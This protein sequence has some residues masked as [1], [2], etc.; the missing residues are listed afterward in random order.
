MSFLC[1]K[2]FCSSGSAATDSQTAVPQ[3][4]IYATLGLPLNLTCTYNCS[5]GWVRS[6]WCLWKVGQSDCQPVQSKG[7]LSEHRGVC[8]VTLALRLASTYPAT[9]NYSCF[10]QDTNSPEL[11]GRAERHVM[12]QVQGRAGL[13]EP[14]EQPCI[15]TASE[16]SLEKFVIGLFDQV[17]R[18]E[19]VGGQI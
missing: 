11:S 16:I 6:D 8:G 2:M 13:K 14:H 3:E 17:T 10:S 5:S 7:S 19:S 15:A 12:V 1:S 18:V 9:H 4:I